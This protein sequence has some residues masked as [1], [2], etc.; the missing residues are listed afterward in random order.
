MTL[1]AVNYD[2]VNFEVH[3][4]TLGVLCGSVAQVSVVFPESS[5]FLHH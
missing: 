3:R 1:L 5:Y 2:S 4:F